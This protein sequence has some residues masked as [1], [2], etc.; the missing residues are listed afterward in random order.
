MIFTEGK[1]ID[2]FVLKNGE[3]VVIRFVKRSDAKGLLKLINSLVAERAKILD[4]KKY[5][6]GE[7]KKWVKEAIGN[8]NEKRLIYVCAESSGMIIG[9]LG[10][11]IGRGATYRIGE[12]GLSVSHDYRR[13][14]IAKK[15]LGT[16]EK[17]CK[18]IY[19]DMIYS[20]YFANNR[21][22]MIF[23]RKMGF[24]KV[25][26]I[27]KALDYYGKWVDLMLVYKK[28]K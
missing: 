20:S 10:I 19:V 11:R 4:N 26:K 14:G 1:V 15:M 24:K 13:F 3:E 2:K 9:G 6:L 28:L 5:T 16:V 21:A 22:S 17:I 18:D 7:E 27:P 25:G 12:L 8:S 23:H